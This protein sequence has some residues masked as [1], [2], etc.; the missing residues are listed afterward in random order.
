MNS[1]VYILMLALL[2]TPAFASAQD[3]TQPPTPA[4]ED[5]QFQREGIFGCNQTGS[6]SMSVGA[7]AARGSIY[8]PV[9]DAAVTLNTGY[10]IYKECV[11]DGVIKRQVESL[12]SG[13]AKKRITDAVSGRGG[14]PQYV[15]NIRY[16]LLE[17]ESKGFVQLLKS[18]EYLSPLCSTFKDKV[19]PAIARNYYMTTQKTNSAFACTITCSDADRRAFL[20]GDMTKC[21]GL[22]G[23]MEYGLNPANHELGAFILARENVEM[24][25]TQL[26]QNVRQ[27][28]DWGDGF[29]AQ[30]DD[31][32]NPFTANIVTPSMLIARSLWVTLDSGRKQLESATEIDQIVSA[33]FSG[34]STQASTDTRGLYGLTQSLGGQPSYLDRMAAESGQGLRNAVANVAI[35]ILNAARQI[36][37][38]FWE[39]KRKIAQTLT[40]LVNQLRSA[41]RQCWNLIIDRVCAT[42]VSGG[43]CQTVGGGTLN[44]ATSTAESQ[45]VIDAQVSPVA[46]QVANDVQAS[47]K[48]VQLINQLIAGVTNTSSVTNQRLALEQLDSLVA[49]KLLH[50]QYDLVAAQKQLEDVNSAVK[51]LV[52]DTIVAW[53]DSTDPTIGWCNVNNQSVLDM[54]IDR[55][56]TQ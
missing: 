25:L 4:T 53:A 28:W 26:E 27:E 51:S 14:N 21:G 15:Q 22:S 48:A 1:R 19:R 45:A 37:T 8:V 12:T 18:E 55:W 34:L 38:A 9:N 47:E 30:K 16:E 23:L 50:N 24:Q 7:L 32:D 29:Y 10:L 49:Q 41:E 39:A 33:L 6:Y 52:E 20:D 43:K 11:L 46:V 56:K 3:A 31:L 54:W 42:P 5:Y 40:S 35:G 2:A 44:V 13:L 36:E 17:E